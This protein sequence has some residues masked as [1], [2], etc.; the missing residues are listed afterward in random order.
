MIQEPSDKSASRR[1]SW[2]ALDRICQARQVSPYL[3]MEV[4]VTLATS[5][6]MGRWEQGQMA[7]VTRCGIM[8]EE[9]LMA[10]TVCG[11]LRCLNGKRIENLVFFYFNDT[12]KIYLT[13]EIKH[14]YSFQ[15]FSYKYHVKSNSILFYPF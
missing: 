2:T 1:G 6:L 13:Y 15:I 11:L 5:V 3:A 12:F 10:M 9:G 4:T 7:A 14:H 8:K